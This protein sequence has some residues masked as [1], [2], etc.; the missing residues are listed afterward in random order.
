[1]ADRSFSASL[2]PSPSIV[3]PIL[4]VRSYDPSN[5]KERLIPGCLFHDLLKSDD[6]EL[7]WAGGIILGNMIRGFASGELSRNLRYR[8]GLQMAPND[9]VVWLPWPGMPNGDIVPLDFSKLP[10][11]HTMF[12]D[13]SDMKF[14]R[15]MDR[16]AQAERI[17]EVW[18]PHLKAEMRKRGAFTLSNEPE[19]KGDSDIWIPGRGQW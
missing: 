16:N 5:G 10:F 3:Y 6:L 19:K 17:K 14:K 11:D 1:M 2:E 8:L 7:A 4:E 9:K 18:V 13:N 15:R 12:L